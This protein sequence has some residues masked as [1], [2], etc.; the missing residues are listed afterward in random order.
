VLQLLPDACA[1]A[2]ICDPPYHLTQLSRGGSPR[3]NNP[4]TPY[5]RHTLADRGFLG[6]VWDGGDIAF[7]EAVWREVLRVAKPGAHLLAF[8]GTRTWHRMVVAIEDA[9][10]VVRDSLAWLRGTGFPKSLNVS[11]AIDEKLGAER[12]VVGTAADFAMD[13][14][15]R[16]EDVD[17]ATPQSGQG[18][19]GFGER[20]SAAVTAPATSEAKAWDGWGTALKPGWEPVVM[21]RK[22]LE[23]SV[24]E[25]V[26]RHGT[27]ALNIDG[28]RI[29]WANQGDRESATPG[30]LRDV[31]HFNGSETDYAL[32]GAPD[33]HNLGRWPANVV[34]SHVHREW[35]RLADHVTESVAT[36]V[37]AYFGFPTVPLV[38]P[39]DGQ[40]RVL[41]PG[42]RVCWSQED[43]SRGVGRVDVPTVRRP[44]PRD[45]GVGQER[46]AQVLLAEVSRSVLGNGAAPV[47]RRDA[48]ERGRAGEDRGD[49]AGAEAHGRALVAV[50]GR[51]V[52]GQ[53]LRARPRKDAADGAPQD[54]AS[55]DAQPLRAGTSGD[56]GGEHR[57]PAHKVGDRSPQERMEDG[58]PRR[59]SGGGEPGGPQPLASGHRAQDGAGAGGELPPAPCSGF[60]EIEGTLIPEGWR[61]LFVFSHAED[62][63][64]VGERKVKNVGGIPV[65]ECVDGCPVRALDEQ[66]GDRPGMSGGG[67]HRDSYEGGMFG[68]IDS[69]STARGDLG[70]ASRF[71]FCARASRAEREFGCEHL[72][73]SERGVRN[74]HPTLKPME[75]MRW[76][77]RLVTP[78]AGLILDPFAG[79]GST[80]CAAVVEGFR[81]FGIEREAAYV[82]IARARIQAHMPKQLDLFG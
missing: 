4:E 29:G 27:G 8:G 79:S 33:A 64:Q 22:P 17:R 35:F 19:H 34:L 45:A 63:R 56:R 36:V 1:D 15:V 48:P 57:A 68:T 24:A 76:L 14:A 46:A 81:F 32:V 25:N 18:R 43:A 20:W 73:P 58:Q 47:A 7:Q 78:K 30:T 82:D 38:R 59:E 77:C 75:L 60:L 52:R 21:A 41:Y 70:G 40:P 26:L 53:R 51:A 72:P 80:G 54:G 69:T 16:S 23:G 5:G 6:E 62:C 49:E 50:E 9:G 42:V 61:D 2:V 65:W 28:C 44:V 12:P 11:A 67:A 31:R 37:R 74:W 39:S 3:T 66:S 71:F 10:W 55:H 13:G